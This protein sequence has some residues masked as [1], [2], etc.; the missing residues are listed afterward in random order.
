MFKFILYVIYLISFIKKII[1]VGE[2]SSCPPHFSQICPKPSEE[3][4]SALNG[5]TFFTCYSHNSISTIWFEFYQ[6]L[7]IIFFKITSLNSMVTFSSFEQFC[8]C[9]CPLKVLTLSVMNVSLCMHHCSSIQNSFA[10]PKILSALPIHPS[11]YLNTWQS[12]I[13]LLSP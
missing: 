2:T 11:L 8:V 12:L 9:L 10:A 13:Y 5:S 3:G 1:T 7:K 6:S 4:I